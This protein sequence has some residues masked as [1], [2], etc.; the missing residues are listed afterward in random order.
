M[1]FLPLPRGLL[2]ESVQRR[3]TKQ[4]VAT[5][6]FVLRIS[7]SDEI[8]LGQARTNVEHHSMNV[9]LKLLNI[10]DVL[11][12][13]YVCTTPVRASHDRH[14]IV[15]DAIDFAVNVTAEEC[16]FVRDRDSVGAVHG[17]QVDKR[18]WFEVELQGAQGNREAEVFQVSN[19]DAAVAQRWLKDKQLEA[20]TN[21]DCLVKEQEKVHLGIKVGANITVTG[22]PGQEGA[23]SNV[24]GKKKV[25]E[26]MKANLGKLLK[27]NVWSTSADQHMAPPITNEI[28]TEALYDTCTTL[29]SGPTCT[30]ENGRSNLLGINRQVD[31]CVENLRHAHGEAPNTTYSTNRFPLMFVYDE[32]GYDAYMK[33]T[34][35]V[36]TLSGKDK[37][38]A[39]NMYY[40]YQIHYRFNCY[41]LL[42]RGAT[43]DQR[44][45]D[46]HRFISIELSDQIEDP[47]GHKVVFEFMMYEPCGLANNIALYMFTI[48]EETPTS[49]KRSKALIFIIVIL[50]IEEIAE[51]AYETSKIKLSCSK[52]PLSY[53]D[54]LAVSL[55]DESFSSRNHVRK[56]LRALPTKW[57]PKVTAIEKSKDLST[58]LLDELI[59]NLKVYEAVLEKDSEVS[60]NKKEKYNSLALKAK[61]VSG[62]KEVSYSDSD[63]EE[64][65][66]AVRDF[67]IFF[68][69]RGKFVSQP[70]D[71]KKN[72]RKAKEEKNGNE[73]RRC[74]K[75]GDPNH[76]IS[77][78]PKHSFNDQKAFVGGF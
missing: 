19:D 60:K 24:A 9:A 73:E 7:T 72:F 36:G 25:K 46:I 62:D 37:W 30:S 22:V 12:M 77:D 74:F 21:T 68:R 11:S 10:H 33:L 52:Y 31:G 4:P 59:G 8:S 61:K 26:S 67:K 38:L 65:A 35:V 14:N 1:L 64:Y 70:H 28:P 2:G 49:I 58:L 54:Q 13:E 5:R 63:D 55:L 18:V 41:S 57:R 45:E 43:K 69:R 32:E 76:F 51:I 42:P 39:M 66:M 44:D 15:S 6:D 71:D 29:E 53:Q 47:E 17:V 34:D 78:C 20:K 56:F 75:C 27:Y 50:L 23:E 16:V 48:E 40:A 3:S